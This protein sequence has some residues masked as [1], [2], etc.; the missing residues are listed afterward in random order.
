MHIYIKIA[1]SDEDIIE[2]LIGD[3]G[4]PARYYPTEMY[5]FRPTSAWDNW[6]NEQFNDHYPECAKQWQ[7]SVSYVLH[8]LDLIKKRKRDKMYYNKSKRNHVRYMEY[9]DEIKYNVDIFEIIT[10]LFDNR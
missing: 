4:L 2:I 8:Q 7:R 1:I 9:H 6:E 3:I 10:N 5:H